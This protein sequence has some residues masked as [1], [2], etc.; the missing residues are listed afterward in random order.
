LQTLPWFFN[1]LGELTV[2]RV[3][4]ANKIIFSLFLNRYPFLKLFLLFILCSVLINMFIIFPLSMPE[5]CA[6]IL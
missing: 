4:S 1:H 6:R 2:T 5:P 3:T